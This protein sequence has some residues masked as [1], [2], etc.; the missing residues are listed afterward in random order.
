M[1]FDL[2]SNNMKLVFTIFLGI[3]L[4][5]QTNAQN[6]NHLFTNFSYAFI[7][8]G[9][10]SGNAIGLDYHRTVWSRF[11]VHVGFSKATGSGDGTLRRALSN[12][13]NNSIGNLTIRGNGNQLSDIAIYSTYLIGANYKVTDGQKHILLASGGLNYNQLK[14]NSLGGTL[15]ENFNDQGIAG[16]VTITDTSVSAYDETG[17][18]FGLDYLYVFNNSISIGLHLAVENS[19]N[20]AYKAGLSLGF[21]F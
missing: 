16:T 1:T 14:Y 7:G 5:F 9:D 4:Q 15:F 21:S 13:S 10:L 2:K 3:L 19:D 11:G 8:T 6:K 20:I 18:Y 17:F 12:N